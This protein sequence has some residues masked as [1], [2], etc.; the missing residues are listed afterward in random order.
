[1]ILLRWRVRK[2]CRKDLIWNEVEQQRLC[3]NGNT[4]VANVIRGIQQQDLVEFYNRNLIHGAPGARELVVHVTSA[5]RDT[6]DEAQLSSTP[7]GELFPKGLLV[8]YQGCNL[9][10]SLYS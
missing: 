2:Q 7:P 8:I 5:K 6:I 4:T 9:S 1:M 10:S 3:F